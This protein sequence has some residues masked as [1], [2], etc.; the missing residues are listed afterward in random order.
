MRLSTQTFHVPKKG[1]SESEYEDACFP[2]DCFNGHLRTYRCAVA[3]G[4]SESAFS[5]EWARLLVRSFGERSFRMEQQQLSWRRAVEGKPLPWYLERKVSDGA[6]AAFVGLSL[7]DANPGESGNGQGGGRWRAFAIGD[8]C[9]FH[10]RGDELVKVGPLSKSEEF[11]NNPLLL[12]TTHPSSFSRHDSLV[13]TLSGTW[14][15]NDSF[16]LATDAL[17][18]WLLSEEEA[19][20]PP[21]GFLRQLEPSVFKRVVPILRES[22]RLHN[23]DTTLLRIEVS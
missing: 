21:W 15:S 14:E 9:L 12:S 11:S 13:N 20:R 8:S 6:H 22:G 2:E 3:D 5:R 16:Y 23:D 4:A 10:I 17:A 1:N 18:Q 19:A 7:R